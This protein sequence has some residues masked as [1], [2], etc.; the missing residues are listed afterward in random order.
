MIAIPY[1]APSIPPRFRLYHGGAA[2][3]GL[4]LADQD[5]ASSFHEVSSQYLGPYVYFST[6]KEYA[7]TYLR[8][9]YGDGPATRRRGAK[10]FVLDAREVPAGTRVLRTGDPATGVNARLW[11]L[12]D[13]VNELDYWR[14]QLVETGAA[15][16]AHLPEFML[17]DHV[18]PGR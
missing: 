15:T 6:L 12:I 4:L 2:K 10:L 13:T 5:T 1:P 14:R 3:R 8:R 16:I 17:P 11:D 7:A 9:S 18:E